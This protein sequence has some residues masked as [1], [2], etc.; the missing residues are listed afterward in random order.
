MG[1]AV[2]APPTA[3]R[4]DVWLDVA[5]LFKTRAEAQR[6]CRGSKVQ[7][8]GVATKPHKLVKVGDEIR[9]TRSLG[10]KQVVRVLALA[11]KHLAKAAAR[12]LYDDQTPPPTPDE[13]ARRAFERAYRPVPAGA[14]DRRERRRLRTLKGLS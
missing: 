5:C 13:L 7:V 10:R 1:L 4:L 2:D 9:V 11:E 6:A 3:V 12:L 8:N 14:P